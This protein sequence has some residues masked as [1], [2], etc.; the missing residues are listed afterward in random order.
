MLDTLLQDVRYGL[1]SLRR[2]PIVVA[3][4]VL[5]LA[6]GIGASTA[7]F[8]AVDGWLRQPLPLPEGDR[9]VRVYKRDPAT[10]SFGTFSA[11]DV[12]AWREA[13]PS[14]RLGAYRR[15]GASFA[16]GEEARR[17]AVVEASAGLAEVLGL[18]PELGR[19]FDGTDEVEAGAL[20]LGHAFWRDVFGG[21]PAVLGRRVALDGT[22]RTVVGVLPP[23]A[24]FDDFASEVWIPLS[25]TEEPD[26]T[27]FVVI[28]RSTSDASLS[29][30]RAELDRVGAA[31][32]AGGRWSAAGVLPLRDVIYGP[33]YAQGGAVLGAAVLFVLLIACANIASLLLARGSRRV[34]EVSL[35]GALGAT[36][37][38]IARQ[39]LTE[40]ALLGVAGGVLAVPAAWLTFEGLERFVMIDGGSTPGAELGLDVR[41]VAIAAAL[42]LFATTVFGLAPAWVGS[43]VGPYRGLRR[44]GT[45]RRRGLWGATLVGGQLC[46]ALL[47]LSAT[48]LVARSLD[49]MGRTDLGVETDGRTVLSV[50]A[51]AGRYATDAEVDAFHDAFRRALAAIPGVTA[52]G[53]S[54]HRPIQGGY[55]VG[56]YHVV[57][58][59]MPE[60]SR[61]PT[62]NVRAA[63]AAWSDAV[64]LDVVAG[65]WFDPGV[66]EPTDVV[67]GRRLAERHWTDVRAALG[68]RIE[69]DGVVRTVVGVS[70]DLS[71]FGPGS[72]APALLVV[73]LEGSG[74]R[75]RSYVTRSAGERTELVPAA[76][77]ALRV[78]DPG[79][80]LYGV[81]S[82]DGLVASAMGPQRAMRRVMGATAAVALLLALVGVYGV[83][84]HRVGERT[85]EIGIRAALGADGG[86]VVRLV[87]RGVATSVAVGLGVG[88][89]LAFAAGPV[90]AF[91]LVGVDP[92]DPVV[93]ATTTGV[94]A[95][96]GLLSALGPALRAARISPSEALRRVT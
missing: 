27:R 17:I 74:A 9:A 83:T 12:Q 61:R 1:R 47:L 11:R 7:I 5:S 68:A 18:G 33:Q 6:L 25:A 63:D 62:T 93:L 15:T 52:V 55:T 89:V 70:E 53:V 54:D 79:V 56:P 42:T 30:T 86:R 38:R 66:S 43:R 58:E 34:E 29:A 39:L 48:A 90:M 96:A 20:L 36:K 3:A 50:E 8:A 57:G 64:E 26:V 24:Y 23:E 95:A 14:V 82:M 32:A 19:T 49:V 46:L 21:D 28:G 40:S 88:G 75:T 16:D 10:G 35:R 51:P 84:A 22:A 87:L 72:P 44:G 67:V 59:E 94:V 78:L 81:D 80:A 77:R 31:T 85:A 65:R 91:A 73:P 2:T 60:E 41:V 76:R 13:S 45:S 69:Y 71:F 4:A 92:R 37:G